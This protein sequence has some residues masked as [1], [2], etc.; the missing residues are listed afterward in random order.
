MR[1]KQF[2]WSPA[3]VVFVLLA[4]VSGGMVWVLE[5]SRQLKAEAQEIGKTQSV[6]LI[7]EAKTLLSDGEDKWFM[8]GDAELPT[9]IG[10]M[11]LNYVDIVASRKNQ[12]GGH[13]RC[14]YGGGFAHFGLILVPDA[15]EEAEY[16]GSSGKELA[17]GV[18]YYDGE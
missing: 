9:V 4:V 18:F 13:V 7:S 14:E 1:F 10:S 15:T 17:S 6:N 8:R 12:G 3:L 2:L 5:E 16:V 11:S